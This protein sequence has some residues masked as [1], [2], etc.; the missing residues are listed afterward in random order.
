MLAEL[1]EENGVMQK[2]KKNSLNR[3][4]IL[5]WS[6]TERSLRIWTRLNWLRDRKRKVAGFCKHDHNIRVIQMMKIP[7]L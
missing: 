1:G 2:N 7:T 6:L 4:I 5:K 3:K